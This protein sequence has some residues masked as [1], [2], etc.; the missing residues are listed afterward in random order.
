MQYSSP[1]SLYVWLLCYLIMQ[2]RRLRR[3]SALGHSSGA[4]Y[5]RGP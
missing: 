5:S 2:L 4:H 3:P 1:V